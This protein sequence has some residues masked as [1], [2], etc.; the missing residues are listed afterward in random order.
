ML[1]HTEPVAISAA[2]RSIVLL[3]VAF[4]LAW[5]PEQIAALM[6]AVEAVLALLVRRKVTP[7]TA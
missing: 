4:G 1:W 7:T 5:S 2:I 6:V 3:A